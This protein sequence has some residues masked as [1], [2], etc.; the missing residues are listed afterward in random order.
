MPPSETATIERAPD[1]M[2]RRAAVAVLLALPE[3][4]GGF[5]V[6]GLLRPQGDPDR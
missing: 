4:A 3:V 2:R 5:F 1:S 6:V